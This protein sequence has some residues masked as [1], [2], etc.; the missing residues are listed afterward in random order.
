MKQTLIIPLLMLT[1]AACDQIQDKPLS[2]P[3]LVL[4]DYL[5]SIVKGDY[6]TAYGRLASPDQSYLT[7]KKFQERIESEHSGR[8]ILSKT[9]F[10]VQSGTQIERYATVKVSFS[11]PDVG[12][13]ALDALMGLI[14]KELDP[15]SISF[16][17]VTQRYTLVVENSS[18]RVFEDFQEKDEEAASQL[19]AEK[20]SRRIEYSETTDPI[21]DSV[22]RT[23][24]LWDE[25][26]GSYLS[27]ST[28]IKVACEDRKVSLSI[29]WP[30]SV[31]GNPK[32]L[33]RVGDSKPV[34]QVWSASSRPFN[35]AVLIPQDPIGFLY[36]ILK[37]DKLVLRTPDDYNYTAV[38]D[39]SG[40]GTA[41][42]PIA[43]NCDW[44]TMTK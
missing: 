13:V 20:K 22:T 37:T 11:R 25:S 30:N 15:D 12:S 4:E 23:L 7:L 1:V 10:K 27:S 5:S 41:I 14:G 16:T 43:K 21:D 32:V 39:T 36:Q 24:T 8:L 19:E 6:S 40:V 42:V 44:S 26:K 33:V 9:T 34:E 38:F 28:N 17:T 3:E 35:G 29:G 2:N 31:R 18:W